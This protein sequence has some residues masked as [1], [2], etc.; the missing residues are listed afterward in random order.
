M[1]IRAATTL[2]IDGINAL[3]STNTS[4]RDPLERRQW[5][6]T[7]LTDGILIVYDL[8]AAT[9]A[10][11]CAAQLLGEPDVGADHEGWYITRIFVVDEHRGGHY[12]LDLFLETVR[13]CRDE[14]G[15]V[16]VY[17][18]SAPP[19]GSDPRGQTTLCEPGTCGTD[20]TYMGAVG[21]RWCLRKIET[22]G[23]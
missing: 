8:G 18:V 17:N 2:D 9:P 3:L 11:V 13:A 1:T 20:F 12:G 5:I 6:E 21:K 23:L 15:A 14:H 10:G 22:A 4:H 19:A 16:E 7:V